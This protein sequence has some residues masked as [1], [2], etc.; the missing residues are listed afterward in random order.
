[1][2][3]KNSDCSKIA[4]ASNSRGPLCCFDTEFAALTCSIAIFD[5]LRSESLF[6]SGGLKK[7]V[8]QILGGKSRL[9]FVAS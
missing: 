9:V 2:V 7:S 1:M 8:F 4:F 5:P 6:I 3:Q